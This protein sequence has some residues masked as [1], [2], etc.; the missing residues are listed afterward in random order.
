MSICI[1]YIVVSTEYCSFNSISG[2]CMIQSY[3]MY[4]RFKQIDNIYV[5]VDV[6][7]GSNSVNTLLSARAA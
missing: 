6:R 1:A 3:S 2:I 7:A 4:D 5:N